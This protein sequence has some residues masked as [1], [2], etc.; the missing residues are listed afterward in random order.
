MP[1]RSRS[2]RNP[3]P[4]TL[5]EYVR[6]NIVNLLVQ[7]GAEVNFDSSN[8]EVFYSDQG[9]TFDLDLDYFGT[10]LVMPRP[11]S[12]RD[13]IE[14]MVRA[15]ASVADRTGVS[16]IVRVA[17]GVGWQRIGRIENARLVSPTKT[18]TRRVLVPSGV[19][20]KQE[21]ADASLK[22]LESLLRGT[23]LGTA[24]D[25]LVQAFA[26]SQPVLATVP[27]KYRK[28]VVEL[29][30]SAFENDDLSAYE[31]AAYLASMVSE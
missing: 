28:Q 27:R 1:T 30:R 17:G 6:Q 2:R 21:V 13:E 20:N 12:S 31:H 3:D 10:F 22:R 23:P 16:I 24:G 14:H 4:Q 18:R 7:D 9:T 8:C 25:T 29:F 26:E 5:R 19:K 15:L 11:R